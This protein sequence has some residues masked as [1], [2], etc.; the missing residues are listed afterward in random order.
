MQSHL[1]VAV[2]VLSVAGDHRVNVFVGLG[3]F[4]TVFHRLH[5]QLVDGLAKVNP[6]WDPEKL[7]QVGRSCEVKQLVGGLNNSMQ[8]LAHHQFLNTILLSFYLSL[9]LFFL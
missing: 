6:H 1:M 2:Y 4:H 3:V 8:S 7:Y 9:S 5:N